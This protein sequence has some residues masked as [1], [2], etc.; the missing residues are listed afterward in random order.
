MSASQAYPEPSLSEQ[1][2][3]K[4]QTQH[5]Q[6]QE[7]DGELHKDQQQQHSQRRHE[8]ASSRSSSG[9]SSAPSTWSRHTGGTTM[10][11]S[12]A[13]SLISMTRAQIPHTPRPMTAGVGPLDP[14]PHSSPPLT[15]SSGP[16]GSPT[17][18]TTGSM[19]EGR[20]SSS[21]TGSISRKRRPSTNIHHNVASPPMAT[22]GGGSGSGHAPASSATGSSG[23][24]T[25]LHRRSRSLGGMLL[26]ADVLASPIGG[27]DGVDPNLVAAIS[28]SGQDIPGAMPL[29]GAEHRVHPIAIAGASPAHPHAHTHAH[30]HASHRDYEAA[31]LSSSP[32]TVPGAAF[33]SSMGSNTGHSGASL[34]AAASATATP[35]PSGTPST[36]KLKKKPSALLSVM[37]DTRALAN[38]YPS[39]AMPA[40]RSGQSPSASP[41]DSVGSSTQ[42]HRL[43]Y[44]EPSTSPTSLRASLGGFAQTP[45]QPTPVVGGPSSYSRSRVRSQTMAPR[46]TG[47]VVHDSNNFRD[48]GD[49]GISMSPMSA[50]LGAGARMAHFPLA[51]AIRLQRVPT[52]VRLAGDLHV[53]ASPVSSR[54]GT[55]VFS[56]IGSE[57]AA[58]SGPSSV[59]V[60]TPLSSSAHASIPLSSQGLGIGMSHERFGSVGRHV[61]DGAAVGSFA[62]PQTPGATRS[63]SPAYPIDNPYSAT[64]SQSSASGWNSPE[65]SIRSRDRISASYVVPKGFHLGSASS[66]ASGSESGAHTSSPGRGSAS[67]SI[68]R[69]VSG[70]MTGAP[71]SPTSRRIEPSSLRG[72]SNAFAPLLSLSIGNMP[73]SGPSS[74]SVSVNSPTMGP[75]KGSFDM[76][77]NLSA[78]KEGVNPT[79][80]A[81]PSR[82][83]TL[84]R[85]ARAAADSDAESMPPPPLPASVTLHAGH[86]HGHQTALDSASHRSGPAPWI[87]STREVPP[88]VTRAPPSSSRPSSSHSTDGAFG[89]PGAH[90]FSRVPGTSSSSSGSGTPNVGPMFSSNFSAGPE[91]TS[92]P[93]ALPRGPPRSPA[94]RSE[95]TQTADTL[96][97]PGRGTLRPMSSGG[98]QPSGTD[99]YSRIIIQSRNAKMHRW[100]S[101]VQARQGV[102]G[103][104]Q[105]QALFR[106]PANSPA[107][108]GERTPMQRMDSQDSAKGLVLPLGNVT[109]G[110]N[111]PVHHN[112]PGT[113]AGLGMGVAPVHS[114]SIGASG[115]KSQGLERRG[116]II[117]LVAR[118]SDTSVPLFSDSTHDLSIAGGPFQSGD[119][120]GSS[121]QAGIPAEGDA[122]GGVWD[123]EWVDWMDE[124]RKMKAA[125]LRSELVESEAEYEGESE[126]GQGHGSVGGTEVESMSQAAPA[127]NTAD[128]IRA[129]STNIGQPSTL[130]A[131]RANQGESA[132]TSR[133]H[134][135]G[136]LA[137]SQRAEF[138]PGGFRRPSGFERLDS[139]DQ[140]RA[141]S[142]GISSTAS[143]TNKLTPLTHDDKPRMVSLSPIPT[144][145]MS[146]SSQTSS[147]TNASSNFMGV[148][149]SASSSARKRKNVLGTKIEN[150]WNAV[151]TGFVPPAQTESQTRAR[152]A[153]GLNHRSPAYHD[154][155][156]TPGSQLP[157]PQYFAP[158]PSLRSQAGQRLASATSSQPEDVPSN[159]SR[160]AEVSSRQTTE[161]PEPA[162]PTTRLIVEKAGS[163]NTID[164]SSSETEGTAEMERSPSSAGPSGT[165]VEPASS[166]SSSRCSEETTGRDAGRKR[167]KYLS[168]ELDKNIS[169]FSSSAFDSLES[170][171][172]QLDSSIFAPQHSP[173]VPSPLA[174]TASAASASAMTSS[175]TAT[176][177]GSETGQA[178]LIDTGKPRETPSPKSLSRPTT[179]EKAKAAAASGLPISSATSASGGS[180]ATNK[181]AGG[182][183]QRSKDDDHKNSSKDP[184]IESIR[185]HVAY[186]ITVCKES[187]DKE[188]C[189]IIAAI[190]QFVEDQVASSPTPAESVA[191][192]SD[193]VE[194]VLGDDD[195]SDTESASGTAQTQDMQDDERQSGSDRDLNI[196]S[197]VGGGIGGIVSVFG[198]L[199]DLIDADET[200][201]PIETPLEAPTPRRGAVLEGRSHPSSPLRAA[202]QRPSK[203]GYPGLPL[204]RH[205]SLR[206][207]NRSAS[208]SR[209]TSR[210]HSPMP[211][212]RSQASLPSY[213]PRLSPVRRFRQLPAEDSPMEPY[214]PALQD[215]VTVAMEVLDTPIQSLTSR[216]GS[217]SGVASNIQIIGKTWD[218]HPDWPGRDWYIKL[219]LAVAGLSRLMQWWEAE[220]VFWNLDDEN[221]QPD[222][223]EPHAE[224]YEVQD[225]RSSQGNGA[226][227]AI[228]SPARN[229]SITGPRRPGGSSSPTPDMRDRRTVSE[230][231]SSRVLA[232]QQADSDVSN[233]LLE[234]VEEIP[235][236][237]GKE[238]VNVLME[239]SLEGRFVYLSPAW[240]TVIGTDLA[241]LYDQPVSDWLAPG[242]SDIFEE[243]TRQL[244][245]DEAHTVEVTFRLRIDPSCAS[246]LGEGKD[247]DA[248][249]FQEMEGKGMLMHDRETRQPTHVMWVFKPTAS[250]ELEANLQGDGAVKGPKQLDDTA[251]ARVASAAT[252]SLEPLLCRIC[253]RD[254]PTW[255]FESHSE[256]CNEIHRLEM[257]IGEINENLAE[258][259]RTIKAVS[260]AL[261]EEAQAGGPAPEFRGIPLSTPPPS[262]QPPSALEGLN[263][264]VAPKQINYMAIRKAHLRVIDAM[265]QML[266]SAKDI[267]TPAIKEDAA[268]EPIERQRL[269]TPTSEARM[270][271]VHQWRPTRVDD[272]AIDSMLV[273]VENA[274]R[275]KLS[276]VN[277]MRNTI[278]YVERVRQEWEDRVEN[279]L[280]AAQQGSD[281]G[282]E[283][284]SLSEEEEI[285]EDVEEEPILEETED[286]SH[287]ESSQEQIVEDSFAIGSR[288]REKT[289]D[290]T[291]Q[292]TGMLAGGSRSRADSPLIPPANISPTFLP[293][294][295][296]S[297]ALPPPSEAA[298]SS[299]SRRASHVPAHSG[300]T[301]PFSPHHGAVDGQSSAAARRLSMS[302]RSP[303][304]S[305]MPLSPRIPPSA[306]SSRPTASSIQDF[307]IIKPISK[308]AFGSVYLARKK[309]TGD[310]FAIKVLK[311]SD[312]I[313]KNQITNA[314]AERKILMDQTSSPFVVKL[315]FTFQSKQYLY[316]VMEYLPGGDCASLCKNLGSLPEE[317]ARQYIAEV[318][319]GLEQLHEKGVVHRDMKPDNLLI[320][321]HGHL[322]L[323][324]FGLSKI[325]LLGRQT[326]N[327]GG[328]AMGHTKSDSASSSTTPSSRSATGP[329]AAPV[330]KMGRGDAL[331]DFGTS[332]ASVTPGAANMFRAQS[333]FAPAQRGR[334]VSSSTDVSDSSGSEGPSTLLRPLPSANLLESPSHVFG[335]NTL[336]SESVN[337]RNPQGMPK[338]VGTPDYLAPESI[339]GIGMDDMAVDWWA[340]GV[341]LYEFIY[342]IPPF[343][344]ETP[345]RVFDNILSRR[346]SWDEDVELSDA[347]RDFMERLMCTDPQQRLGTKGS[348]EVK[349]HPFFAGFD[350]DNVAAGEGPFVPQV[351]DPESTD[352]FDLRGAAFQE[353]TDE[354]VRITSTTEFANALSRNSRFMETSRP[355]ARKRG[356]LPLETPVDQT[357]DEFGSFTF[358]N[359]PVLKQ[360]N[361]EILRKM[362]SD[363]LPPAAP[364]VETPLM[365]ARHRSLS[366]KAG[367]PRTSIHPHHPP[368]PVAGH[369][370]PSP[371]TSVS[372]QSSAPSRSTAP[373]S[374]STA[375]PY[376]H[377]T[378]GPHK[379]RPSEFTMGVSASA[380]SLV[381]VSNAIMD[382]KRSLLAEGE[383]DAMSRNSSRART[384]SLG[385]NPDRA[386]VPAAQSWQEPTAPLPPGGFPME[387]SFSGGS[388]TGSM[389]APERGPAS[390]GTRPSVSATSDSAS[391]AIL[392]EHSGTCLIA[393]D[394]PIALRMLENILNKLGLRTVSTRSGAEA[395]QL[396]MGDVRYSAM[397]IDLT[398]PIVS[399]QDAARMLKSTRNANS[400]TPIIAL[401]SF[402]RDEQIDVSH[403]NFDAVVAKP[404]TKPDIL[405]A[406]RQLNFSP[407]AKDRRGFWYPPSTAASHSTHATTPALGSSYAPSEGTSVGLMGLVLDSKRTSTSDTSVSAE[408]ISMG[409][410]WG[411]SSR[412]T[413]HV[414]SG[415]TNSRNA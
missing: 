195:D 316:L 406:L 111:A 243:A 357:V 412:R 156:A 369:G 97:N 174:A 229:I 214:I 43:S 93:N 100:K 194:E 286:R 354:E 342:G 403:S 317:W 99:E 238:A 64:A 19:G 372:S 152:Q 29:K 114:G 226:P 241:Q 390:D 341:I 23:S 370:P 80:S 7:Q 27:P 389:V 146:T 34:P 366:G 221:D 239:L 123:I 76:D 399:G 92:I 373:T 273:E 172:S 409:S 197:A 47:Q 56:M 4:L 371:S 305:T 59:P 290:E 165:S 33:P 361:D 145:V 266:Q 14:Q 246:S 296:P 12:G 213:S 190:S 355:P 153:F 337:A 101:T 120:D 413:S 408:P 232:V 394:N 180:G 88:K 131:D 310:Y 257:E 402:D 193:V 73:S 293:S 125:K 138:L 324:D 68:S 267:S 86:Q 377:N 157:Q 311:K 353:F 51:D 365:H 271:Q 9:T 41:S 295:L 2:D 48:A 147:S 161:A 404:L 302:H 78:R 344:A 278:V 380:S 265:L 362:R 374:P 231:D 343:H 154:V 376:L 63:S 206:Q 262:T 364:A 10:A 82:A 224:E 220:M 5:E 21:A 11:G 168:L 242:D 176:E 240:T 133:S 160:V 375:G 98:L 298:F 300:G 260:L 148:G 104:G 234:P 407:S 65:M 318:I 379:R 250:P 188:L 270:V 57:L 115:R 230:S 326:R 205:K 166:Q 346:I 314:K 385:A 397:F 382:R 69:R 118:E 264:S 163:I 191:D 251:A 255:F 144:R 90:L 349:A 44:H 132:T 287:D 282:E 299:R 268:A 204:A 182:G 151:K 162:P 319:N 320:D 20:S 274:V 119:G 130:T 164:M 141:V 256:I 358:K 6:E 308:G 200:A 22:A 284:V 35:G 30:A 388:T 184:S 288:N 183:S 77:A 356:T 175:N 155:R 392:S 95:G 3:L 211:A 281:S 13:P 49:S 347:A 108:G 330:T 333:F 387:T 55:G 186:R 189:R 16:G 149:A 87:T 360:A 328:A 31:A 247:E 289:G 159:E 106:A 285:L 252:I 62:A 269:L 85:S 75:G 276:G 292:F 340:L 352:Y 275:A 405:A 83:P 112:S 67:G 137:P 312:M 258:L 304:V 291:G 208:T 401:A 383:I 301:P 363:Q 335:S 223:A 395:T 315:F 393:E 325:G 52:A 177:V 105:A 323:T 391:A 207:Y 350:W 235:N 263:K 233:Q 228:S 313:A 171:T 79:G 322:K 142:V 169:S 140:R 143:P 253:E 181:A 38:T 54:R 110:L 414:S 170:S 94:L 351:T 103:P 150:W 84:S 400:L 53:P 102:G 410:E 209:S 61:G 398:L 15:A 121:K 261:V 91:R 396:A 277:R 303:Q 24:S 217:I 245:L 386:P 124:Y 297:T 294:P 135:D 218:S 66:D 201:Q 199:E 42:S 45:S 192:D 368:P 249:Y 329:P 338:F 129:T 381:G 359:L 139:D 116:T 72:T 71:P 28:A 280:S 136:Q 32:T 203:G 117:G 187:C 283:A 384:S 202:V 109:G 134:S 185:Q 236:S 18:S 279:A 254:I 40:P 196:S 212:G 25:S 58:I 237:P 1:E 345:D 127:E 179:A 113:S 70:I 96:T 36:N 334:I 336:P 219:L 26:G 128:G 415:P 173:R 259:R 216:P 107:I 331:S 167:H 39:M 60:H 50:S 225:A 272:A 158:G 198:D 378:V 37:P 307:E 306:P 411:G 122:T 321:Q 367:K 178:R 74:A 327:V 227:S 126:Y 309:T 215:L 81:G 8:R 248:T 210:S 244:Q 332:P 89:N 17:S 348:G 46:P 339:L 222:S